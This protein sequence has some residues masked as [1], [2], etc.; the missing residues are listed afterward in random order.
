MANNHDLQLYIRY[1]CPYCVRVLRYMDRAGIKVPL[2]DIT[3]S[4]DDRLFLVR[5]GGKQQVP[6]LFIDGVAMYESLDIIDWM[7]RELT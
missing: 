4:E 7:E 6:C 1:T 5:E 3:A 2:H